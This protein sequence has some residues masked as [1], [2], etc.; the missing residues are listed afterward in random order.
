MRIMTKTMTERKN[1]DHWKEQKRDAK[2]LFLPIEGRPK[3]LTISDIR[4]AFL[5]GLNDHGGTMLPSKKVELYVRKK[6]LL[7]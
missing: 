7:D 3:K 6:R 2:G 1:S 5:A 4:E